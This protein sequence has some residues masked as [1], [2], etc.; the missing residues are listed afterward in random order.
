M[1]KIVIALLIALPFITNGQQMHSRE[2]RLQAADGTVLAGQLDYPPGG[3][4]LPAAILIWGNGPHTREASISGTPVFLQ[5]AGFLVKKGMAV[6]RLDKR[7]FGKS[8]GTF[9]SEGHYTTRDLADDI[10]EAYRYLARDPM[11]DTSRIGLI[12]HSEGAL[13]AAMLA[14]ETPRMGFVIM[15]GLPAVRGD[16]IHAGQTARNRAALGIPEATSQAVAR[17]WQDYYLY[18]T[19]GQ[20]DDSAYYAIGRRFLIAHGLKDDDKR[21]TPAFIDQLLS[22]YRTAWHRYFFSLDPAPFLRRIQS[23]ALAIYGAADTQ[24]TPAQ[25]VLPLYEAWQS[26]GPG[27]YRV[28]ILGDE[29]HFFLR[30]DGRRLEKHRNGEMEVS[31]RLLGLMGH[32]LEERGML[33]AAPPKM[34]R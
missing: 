15:L 25:N 18:L 13:I 9:T 7:G 4:R 1:L 31:P 27:D 20:T 24:T 22:G 26:G 8:G 2:I 23:P 12:G 14:A 33:H 10:R 28:V 30:H 11:I 21:I 34:K 3:G 6:L 32:W 5:M 17:V 16:G 19:S 29:D